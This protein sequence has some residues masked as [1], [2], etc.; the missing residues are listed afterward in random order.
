M[1]KIK[2]ILLSSSVVLA[3][4]IVAQ[5]TAFDETGGDFGT[6]LGDLLAFFNNVLI[7][8][9]LGLGFLIFVW[10]MFQ[11]F[12]AGGADEEKRA[13][14]RSV[15]IWTIIGFVLIIVFWGIINIV[16]GG[17]GLGGE[18]L[19]NTLLPQPVNLP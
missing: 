17:T 13:K 8:F 1:K 5:A 10:G 14:G 6:F 11:Y 18:Q 3:L 16:V 4:P 12:I 15:I 19:D 9:I 2:N 7:P